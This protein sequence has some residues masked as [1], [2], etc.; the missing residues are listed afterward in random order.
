MA[1]FLIR[2]EIAIGSI[3]SEIDDFVSH[4]IVLQTQ[5]SV[6]RITH[7]LN[8]SHEPLCIF[9]SFIFIWLTMHIYIIQTSSTTIASIILV[10]HV[11]KR[12]WKDLVCHYKLDDLGWV[13][14]ALGLSFLIYKNED[15]YIYPLLSLRVVARIK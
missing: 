15:D 2:S 6:S 1:V 5:K 10:F 14:S 12:P 11:N 7:N 8:L 3:W 4:F 13:R 9:Q